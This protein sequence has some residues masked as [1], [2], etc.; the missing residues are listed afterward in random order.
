MLNSPYVPGKTEGF[1]R[2]S[3]PERLALR[4]SEEREDAQGSPAGG[5]VHSGCVSR[6]Y[7]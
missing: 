1:R 3:E 4:V 5:E 7:L 2:E 6:G